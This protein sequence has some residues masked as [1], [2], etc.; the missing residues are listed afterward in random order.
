MRNAEYF[1]LFC[2]PNESL[3]KEVISKMV[4]T[5]I[6]K[7]WGSRK[8][9][10][11]PISISINTSEYFSLKIF[12]IILKY[13][14]A[15]CDIP[16]LI[17]NVSNKISSNF[18]YIYLFVNINTCNYTGFVYC[19]VQG[20]NMNPDPTYLQ[21]QIHTVPKVYLSPFNWLRYDAHFFLLYIQ[22]VQMVITEFTHLYS[23]QFSHVFILQHSRGTLSIQYFC[24]KSLF[25]GQHQLFHH[26]D[27]I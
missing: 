24:E 10:S 15:S 22:N 18:L 19:V 6:L 12:S 2:F 17:K 9:Q 13:F 4:M 27:M 14:F 7:R 8:S 25:L 26:K 23:F 21:Y 1:G 11:Y 16:V 5:Y 3:S 20:G